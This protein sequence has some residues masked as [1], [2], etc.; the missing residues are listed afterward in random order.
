M[1]RSRLDKGGFTLNGINLALCENPLPP[2]EEAIDVAKAQ[3]SL[4]NHC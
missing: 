2:V 1:D 4:C 3:A